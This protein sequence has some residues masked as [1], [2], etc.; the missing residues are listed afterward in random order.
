MGNFE[1]ALRWLKQANIDYGYAQN[2]LKFKSFELVCFLSHQV[3]EKSLKAILYNIGLRPFG[4]SLKDLVNEVEKNKAQINL[5]I[6]IECATELDKHYISTRNPDA[7]VS[8]IPHEY[9]SEKNAK[10]C[11]KWSKTILTLVENYLKSISM[12]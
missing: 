2:N 4:H 1:E 5:E 11:L 10:D 8:G 7:F 12:K 6:P 3:A 9:Y